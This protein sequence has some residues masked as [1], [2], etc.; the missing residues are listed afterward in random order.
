ML[1]GN[2]CNITD[3][4][5]RSRGACGRSR[6]DSPKHVTAHD[7]KLIRVILQ[8]LDSDDEL[9]ARYVRRRWHGIHETRRA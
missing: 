4:A 8:T 7:D 3:S 5:P 6:E 9:R 1:E 2:S